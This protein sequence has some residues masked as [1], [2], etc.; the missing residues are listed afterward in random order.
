MIGYILL[1]TITI[2]I[3]LLVYQWI[4][5]Y[6]PKDSIKCDEGV[7]IFIKDVNYE[8]GK[9]NLTIKNNG[10]FNVA[11]F[12]IH[13]TNNS[14]KELATIDLSG[15]LDS[16]GGGI[17]ARNAII[18]GGTNKNGIKSNEERNI[19]FDLNEEIYSIE[20]TPVRYQEEDNRMR[21]V[22]C[23]NAK[24]SERLTND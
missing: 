7:S 14:E 16:S 10:L 22:I 12:I 4:S 24:T 5:S 11:G 19:L 1:V 6:I 9:L 2:V 15:N 18:F 20:I 3:S 21:F 8:N 23:G 17:K 13:G